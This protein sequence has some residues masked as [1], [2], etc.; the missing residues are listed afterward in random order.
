MNKEEKQ[1]FYETS[2]TYSTLNK[3]TEK[4]ENVWFACHGL[5]YLSRFFI[6]H[7]K[8][9]DAEKNY[10]I[11][12]QAQAKYYQKND[13]KYVGASWLTKEN[14]VEETQNVLTYMDAVYNAEAIPNR[15]KLIVFGFSQG[16]SVSTRWIVSR[17]INPDILVIYAGSLP[18]ELTPEDFTY[19]ADY[20]KVKLIYGTND[21]YITPERL[22]TEKEFA[23]KLFGSDRL[24]IISFEGTHEMRPEMIAKVIEK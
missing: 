21:Q 18:K 11:A 5:G 12:P 13:F 22:R 20:T 9:L 23:E 2:N 4:T 6:N 8:K 3:L 24:E 17:Q 15:K 7:F 14:T 16:V 1:V 19:L 10:V